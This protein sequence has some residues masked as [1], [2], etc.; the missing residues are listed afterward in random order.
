MAPL[1]KLY[2]PCPP[3]T[4]NLISKKPKCRSELNKKI[5]NKNDANSANTK[6][7][8]AKFLEIALRR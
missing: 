2:Q 6:M 8:H 7:T 1:A 4:L 5:K 3:L